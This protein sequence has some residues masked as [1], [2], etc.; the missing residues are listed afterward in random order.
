MPEVP[1]FCGIKK[2]TTPVSRKSEVSSTSAPEEILFIPPVNDRR[3]YLTVKVL[4]VNV[5]GLLDCGA[6]CS[7]LGD[8]AHLAFLSLGLELLMFDRPQT[9]SVASGQEL[10]CRYYMNL[11]IQHKGRVRL[12]IFHVQ[13]EIKLPIHFGVNFWKAF[14]LAPDVLACLPEGP[15]APTVGSIEEDGLRGYESLSP[16]QRGEMDKVRALFDNINTDRVGLGRTS[17]V[18]HVINT[19]DAVPIKQKYYRLSPAKLKYLNEEVDR[20]LANGVVEPSHSPWNSPV[21]MV[22]KSNGELR[23]CLDS[24]RLNAVSKTD[25]YP[26]PYIN[27]ILDNLRDARYLSS[28]DLSAAYHQIPLHPDSKEKTGFS[29]PN[30]GFFHY[31][32]MCFGLVGASATMQ[33]LMDSLFAVEFDNKVFAYIDDIVICTSTFEEHLQILNRVYAKLKEAN[34]TI[35]M[36]KSLF[37]R[38]ELKYL[39]YVVDRFG[40]RTDPS[41]VEVIMNFPVPRDAKEVKRY[42][43]LCGWYRR[44]IDNFSKVARPLTR[45]TSKKV[46][47]EWSPEADEAFNTL[48]SALISAPILKCPDFTQPFYVHADASSFAIG[49][50]LTQKTDGVDHPIAYC[51]RTLTAQE[52]N[53]T[54]TERE[55]LAVLFALEQYRS[56][57]EGSKC[58]I[59]TDHASL[60]WFY[61]LKNPTGRLNRWACRLSQFEFEIIHRKGKEHVIPDAL[62]RI[63]ID[64]ITFQ[65][66]AVEDPWYLKLLKDCTDHP[67][68]FPNFTVTDGRLFRLSKNKYNLT[69]QFEWKQVVPLEHRTE[70]LKQFHDDPTSSHFGVAKTHKRVSAVYYWPSLHRDVERYVAGCEVCN[71]YKPSNTA[72]AGLMGSPRVVSKPWEAISCDILGPFPPSYARNQYLFVCCDYFSK[73]TLLFPLRN[74]TA[75]SIVKCLE[76]GVFLLHGICKFIYVDNGPQFISAQF[77]DLLSR[78]QVPHIFY[79][80]RYHPQVNFTERRNRDLVRAISSYVR[81][82]H[83]TW[84]Q[85]IPE[86]QCALNTAVHDSTKFTPFFLNH[87]REM[88]L[89]G[90]QYNTEE[91]IEDAAVEISSE[92]FASNLPRLNDI[93][94]TVQN[95]LKKAYVHNVRYYNLRKRDVELEE[96]Q[97]V[98]KRCFPLSSAAK[99]FSAKLSP[100]YEKCLVE[101][102]HSPLVYS[103]KSLTGKSLG[104]FHIKDILARGEPGLPNPEP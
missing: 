77:R 69:S 63:R 56:Y 40:L 96:G 13:P 30:R 62:S 99:F 104:R 70:L 101:R 46:R 53:Y 98:Y 85:H 89:N 5:W 88:V 95:H 3:P 37:C 15:S 67:R 94:K 24:R 73:Y 55:L 64:S 11:P 25:A 22:P 8:N 16:H 49:G 65:P 7:V 83:R 87:G 42:L 100:K 45:L 9:L 4:N 6:S 61:K 47:F 26:L 34:L 93:Y 23:L 86:I 38:S 72:R 35:N 81:S 18:Q 66:D 91:P 21:T 41:K 44:F 27:Y 33:R 78:Y 43:G 71:C 54:A 17:L 97:I 60:Q 79:N 74:V 58:Y 57:V 76:K 48:K 32:V 28:L 31:N 36:K 68:R 75:K 92:P 103:L 29:V 102:K 51:S 12:V 39:G 20:M 14:D 2:L 59:V 10:I 80:P 84:D 1:S 82:D 50:V 90:A 52:V 19:G